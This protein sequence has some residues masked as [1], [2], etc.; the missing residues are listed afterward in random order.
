M[1]IISW[2]LREIQS[3]SRQ[4]S[5]RNILEEENPDILMLQETKCLG[6]QAQTIIQRHWRQVEVV[7]IDAQG[8]SGGIALAWIPE[9]IQMNTYWTTRK[10]ITTQFHYR[11]MNIQGFITL[12]YDPNA[13]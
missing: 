13:P 9:S 8:Y 7:T 3:K 5:L 1:K 11:G 4:R 12:V 10:M 2:N 6:Q